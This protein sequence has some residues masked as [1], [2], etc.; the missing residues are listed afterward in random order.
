[1]TKCD[2]CTKSDPKGKCF[3]SSRV[4]AEDDCREAIKKMVKAFSDKEEKKGWL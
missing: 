2:F 4:A 3:W 1:M